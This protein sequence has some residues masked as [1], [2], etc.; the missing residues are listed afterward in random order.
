MKRIMSSWHND[1]A[2][3]RERNNPYCLIRPREIN[4]KNAGKLKA[5]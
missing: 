1:A 4:D 5:E 3:P 2:S